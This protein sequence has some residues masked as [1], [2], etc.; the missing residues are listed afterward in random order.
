[1]DSYW[2]DILG[3]FSILLIISSFA[4]MILFPQLV[5]IAYNA[6]IV[7]MMIGAFTCYLV[8]RK[9]PDITGRYD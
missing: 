4:L 3:A 6:M 7:G 1:M 8:L 9:L 5:L 2:Y